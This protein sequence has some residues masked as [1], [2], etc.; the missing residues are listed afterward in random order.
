MVRPFSSVRPSVTVVRPPLTGSRAG[1]G[2][3]ARRRRAPARPAARRGRPASTS[4]S[5]RC[6]SGTT[7]RARPPGPA[8][9]W[10]SRWTA[11]I[12]PAARCARRAAAT[13]GCLDEHDL[14]ELRPE[15]AGERLQLADERGPGEELRHDDVAALA[16]RQP[17]HR[18]APAAAPAARPR[19][20]RSDQAPSSPRTTS[21]SRHSASGRSATYRAASVDLPLPGNP[22]ISSRRGT[23]SVRGGVR[24]ACRGCRGRRSCPGRRRGW[25]WAW[26]R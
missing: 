15:L 3:S 8:A 23:V 22:L 2:R 25:T 4:C 21:T 17:G 7:C 10:A 19:A 11:V 13:S 9:A 20:G 26:C 14:D 12:G 24:R 5:P 1:P 16:E 18:Q 6:S